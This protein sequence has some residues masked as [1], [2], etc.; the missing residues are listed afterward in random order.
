MT[1]EMLVALGDEH[2][3]LAADQ[4]RDALKEAL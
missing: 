1:D 3:R 4:R 2:R